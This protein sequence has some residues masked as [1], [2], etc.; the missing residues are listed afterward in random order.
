MMNRILQLFK[1]TCLTAFLAF[2]HPMGMLA[3]GE[4]IFSDLNLKEGEVIT[5][6]LQNDKLTVTFQNGTVKYDMHQ[7]AIFVPYGTEIIITANQGEI[8]TG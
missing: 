1:I 3:G 8:I 5:S 6:P 7:E 4:L 2:L